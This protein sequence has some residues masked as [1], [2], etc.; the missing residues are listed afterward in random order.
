VVAAASLGV[1]AWLV[2]HGLWLLGGLGLL[3]A[4]AASIAA[5]R[6]RQADAACAADQRGVGASAPPGPR[7][8]AR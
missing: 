3:L 1:G 6:L 7:S 8:G 5:Y 2:A 4:G